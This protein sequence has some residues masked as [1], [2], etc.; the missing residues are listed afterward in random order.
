MTNIIREY[1]TDFLFATPSFLTG[2]GS[3]FNIA[4]DNYFEYNLSENGNE[5]DAKA[6]ASDWGVVGSDIMEALL[7][8]DT[9]NVIE[10]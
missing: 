7:L 6:L 3:I 9:E 1:R 10:N 5:A 8:F 4:G 2:M